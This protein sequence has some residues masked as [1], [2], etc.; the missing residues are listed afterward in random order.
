MKK[1]SRECGCVSF[2]FRKRCD[3]NLTCESVICNLLHSSHEDTTVPGI[4]RVRWNYIVIAGLQVDPGRLNNVRDFEMTCVDTIPSQHVLQGSA[5]WHNILYHRHK[6]SHERRIVVAPPWCEDELLGRAA[7][8]T[9]EVR[10]S[11][12]L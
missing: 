8:A 3:I 7:R 6:R 2:I 5:I 11:T 12:C 9:E 10:D 4:Y 1:I